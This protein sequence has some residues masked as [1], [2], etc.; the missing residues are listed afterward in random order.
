MVFVPRTN[1]AEKAVIGQ[2]ERSIISSKI[3]V[4]IISID[5][6]TTDHTAFNVF[7]GINDSVTTL[8]L[9]SILSFHSNCM[10]HLMYLAIKESMNHT[11]LFE[12]LTPQDKVYAD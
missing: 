5:S 12:W 3:S 7:I 1:P 2:V 4:V 8:K 6:G 9:R 10:V 11:L